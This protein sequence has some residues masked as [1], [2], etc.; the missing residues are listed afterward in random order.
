[1]CVHGFKEAV[2]GPVV[3]EVGLMGVGAFAAAGVVW[4]STSL[5]RADPEAGFFRFFLI[6]LFA[7]ACAAVS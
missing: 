5:F 7:P 1:M 6:G 3:G 2:P 4:Q